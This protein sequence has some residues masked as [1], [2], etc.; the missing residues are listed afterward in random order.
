MVSGGSDKTMRFAVLQCLALRR[1]KATRKETFPRWAAFPE[2]EPNLGDCG[3]GTWPSVTAHGAAQ[4]HSPRCGSRCAAHGV[5]LTVRGSPRAA[6][7]PRLTV[8]GPGL[9]DTGT[10]PGRGVKPPEL[11]ENLPDLDQGKSAVALTTAWGPPH[12]WPLADPGQEGDPRSALR[13]A[14]SRWPRLWRPRKRVFMIWV[15]G[16]VHSRARNPDHESTRA[17]AS[18]PRAVR[19]RYAGR[20]AGRRHGGGA[21]QPAPGRPRRPLPPALTCR[22]GW[23]ATYCC[24]CRWR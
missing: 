14:Q 8:R 6:H 2:A 7:G 18:E 17:P 4:R 16:A 11:P 3:A 10:P 15:P 9:R 1:P 21:R 23:T 22:K 13:S 5:R 19:R 24:R 12:Q 20:Y